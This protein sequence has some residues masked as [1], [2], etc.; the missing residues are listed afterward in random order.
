[1]WDSL[2]RVCTVLDG[3]S[4]SQSGFP[5]RVQVWVLQASAIRRERKEAEEWPTHAWLLL[6]GRREEQLPPVVLGQGALRRLNGFFLGTA[7]C[8]QGVTMHSPKG[9]H[10]V[11]FSPLLRALLALEWERRRLLVSTQ[12]SPFAQGLSGRAALSKNLG[13]AVLR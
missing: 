10:K 3:M 1:M 13:M 6:V 12:G 11:L 9:R 8:Q 4:C 7:P 2:C 5:C